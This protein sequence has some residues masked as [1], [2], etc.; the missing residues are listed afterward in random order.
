MYH[1]ACR[2]LQ[3]RIASSAPEQVLVNM[4]GPKAGRQRMAIAAEGATAHSQLEIVQAVKSPA[5]L[6]LLG[7]STSTATVTAMLAFECYH[8]AGA[9]THDP[10]TA[11]GCTYIHMF[12]MLCRCR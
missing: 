2:L 7:R 4:A 9:C 3:S 12:C 11:G 10:I 8:A 5:V 6:E 1:Q